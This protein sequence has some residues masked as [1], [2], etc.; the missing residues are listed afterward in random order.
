[1][2]I[3]GTEVSFDFDVRADRVKFFEIHALLTKVGDGL[4]E[5]VMERV[6]KIGLGDDVADLI[7]SDGRYSTLNMAFLEFTD[8]AIDQYEAAKQVEREIEEKA[9]AVLGKVNRVTG[10]LTA[11]EGEIDAATTESPIGG[12]S[13]QHRPGVEVEPAG[14]PFGSILERGVQNVNAGQVGADERPR[15]GHD[16]TKHQSCG[17][18]IPADGRVCPV[19]E[20]ATGTPLDV[21]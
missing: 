12:D 9:D 17:Q 6:L 16:S 8:Q 7:L 2:V 1:M 11:E 4:T 19:A 14:G 21:V 5:A 10:R 18:N 13:V 3:R 20:R 15:V